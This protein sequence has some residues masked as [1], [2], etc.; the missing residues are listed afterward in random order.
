MRG[1]YYTDS[2]DRRR[3]FHSMCELCKDNVDEVD[4]IGSQLCLRDCIELLEELGYCSSDWEVDAG[5]G[6]I[7]VTFYQEEYPYI[8]ILSDGY[9][10]RLKM[11]W[12][13]RVSVD[14]E[15][16]KELMRKHWGKYFPVI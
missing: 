12:P 16:V 3:F 9:L 15:K 2:E 8:T 4:M 5:E 6:E 10:G 13:E 11:F 7:W 1:K 14:N